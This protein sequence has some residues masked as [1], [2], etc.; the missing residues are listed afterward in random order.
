MKNRRILF[1]IAFMVLFTVAQA[2][3]GET[4]FG[5]SYNV[6]LPMGEFKNVVSNT[7]F[8]GFNASILHGVSDNLSV[9]FVTGFQDFYQKNARQTYHFTDGSDVSA[10]V[11]NTVQTIPILV[12]AKYNFNPTSNIQPYAAIGVGGNMVVYNTLYG[13]FGSQQSKFGFAARPE[14]GLMIPF[15]NKSSGF[16]IGASY[17]IMPFKADGFT[18]L[19]NVGIHAGINVPLRK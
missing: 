3:K 13:E 5:I 6:A 1:S 4:K 16:E 19:N 18:N 8:S 14:V 12:D 9:G 7:S 2:Q 11:T 10:V 17:N 15:K